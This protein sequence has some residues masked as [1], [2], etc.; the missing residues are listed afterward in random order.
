MTITVTPLTSTVLAQIA[1][2][3]AGIA[4]A[5][6]NAISRVAGLVAV[7][8]VGVITGSVLDLG[9]FHRV[10]IVVAVLLVVSGLVSLIGLPKGVTAGREP[11]ESTPVAP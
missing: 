7:A 1:P 3:E 4:S 10:L 2:A 8:F 5:V 9:G 6:N 11:V